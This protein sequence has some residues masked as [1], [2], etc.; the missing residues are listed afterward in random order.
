[1]KKVIIVVLAVLVVGGGVGAS[2]YLLNQDSG[3]NNSQS[4]SSDTKSVNEQVSIND[5]LTRNAS[6]RCTYD[7]VEGESTNTGVAYFSGAKDMYGEFTNATTNKSS[8]AYVIRRGDTQYVWQKDATEGYKADVSAYDKDKQQQMSQSLDPDQKY[9]FSCKDWNRDASK[10]E[11]PTNIK[12][13]DI[14][15]QLNQAQNVSTEAR[16][17]ACEALSNADAKTAC[18]NAIN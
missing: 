3:D 15:S 2:L 7:V 5:L 18:K 16:E 10:F 6:L 12:F 8:T 17:Q 11:L 14:S 4:S 9:Q 13:T 1:M